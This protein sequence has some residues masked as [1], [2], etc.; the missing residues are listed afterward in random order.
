[1][2]DLVLAVV[3]CGAF[4]VG[5]VMAGALLVRALFFGDYEEMPRPPTILGA[6]DDD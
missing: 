4:A 2:I 5:L 3:L 1:M 6:D